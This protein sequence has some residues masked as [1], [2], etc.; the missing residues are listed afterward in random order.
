M[1]RLLP[2]ALLLLT[3]CSRLQV[4]VGLRVSLPKIQIASIEA[5]LPK[6]PGIAPGERSKM[7]V[8]VTQPNG[9]ILLTAGAGHGKVLWSDLAVV[10]EVVTAKKGTL[11]LDPD[12]RGTEGKTGHVSITVPSHPGLLTELT[13]PIRYDYPFLANHSGGDGANGSDGSAGT[14]GSPGSSGSTDPNNPSPGGNGSDGG[15]GGNGTS[16]GDGGNGDNV[17]VLATLHPGPHPLVEFSV[18]CL[19]CSETFFL[20][21]PQGGTMSITALGGSGGSGGAGGKGGSG[22]SGGIGSPNGSD[23]RAGSD[24]SPGSGGSSGSPGTITITY[25]PSIAPYLGII[26]ANPTPTYHTSTIAPLW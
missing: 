5:S 21:D 23:G 9:K 2:L 18:N 22:G 24:G 3:G 17:T 8:K 6:N 11:F 26:R 20:V 7:I 4:L 16:G 15:S 1:R 13:V 25:D 10:T 19:N 12:P 14:P